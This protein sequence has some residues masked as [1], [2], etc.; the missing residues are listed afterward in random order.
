MLSGSN[1]I[2]PGVEPCQSLF[3]S[4]CML[5]AKRSAG[6]APEMNRICTSHMPMPLPSANKA[7]HSGFEIQNRGISGP[8]KRTCVHQ[9]N[10][11]FSVA[12]ATLFA[13]HFA[14]LL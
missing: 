4:M 7:A 12:R 3:A 1:T 2:D 6:V 14:V 8:T 5:A 9:K 10:P 11:F 13:F